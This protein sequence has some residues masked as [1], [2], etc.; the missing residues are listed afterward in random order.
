[1]KT[2]PEKIAMLDA[3]LGVYG[4]K[5]ESNLKAY[6]VPLWIKSSFSI[7]KII[8]EKKSIYL[9]EPK[10]PLTYDQI[11]NGRKILER[12][13]SSPVIVIA[14]DLNPKYRSL[15]VRRQ[16]P[17]IY[18]DKTLFA[19]SLGIKFQEKIKRQSIEEEEQQKNLN[20]FELKILSGYLTEQLEL[21]DFNLNSLQIELQ[22]KSYQCSK[23]KLSLT[24]KDLLNK[25]LI[26][27]QGKGPN[28]VLNFETRDEVWN[29]MHE[30]SIAKNHKIF[31]SSQFIDT[32]DLTWSGE[33]AL[34]KYSALNAPKN[35][36]IAITKKHYDMMK[37]QKKDF[38]EK[39]TLIDI[40][41]ED[42]KL[43]S[44]QGCINPIELYFDLK[45]SAD[46]RIQIALDEMLSPYT[47]K[48]IYN[49]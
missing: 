27:E 35:Q 4:R 43:F 40:R 3:L 24:V 23:G 47:L 17:Y 45:L 8:Y 9:V 41:K 44:I 20:P 10:E 25:G 33:S 15:F 37:K 28:R 1:M 5:T 22:N 26:K 38:S 36:M 14:D 11:V 21:K 30:I 12:Q 42:P 34:A 32:I 16:V 31:E 6:Q 29:K 7:H 39:T 13:L 49:A 46:E 2:L 18:K 19:P 48:G